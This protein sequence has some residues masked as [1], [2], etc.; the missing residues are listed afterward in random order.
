MLRINR[1][2]DY[3][4]A[5]L[6]LMAEAPN[7]RYSAAWLSAERGLPSPVVSKILKQLVKGGLLVSHRGAK[8]G[9]SL[10]RP[11]EQIS[12]A[13]VITAIEGPIALTDCIEGGGSACQY[14]P[15]CAVSHNW[16]RLNDV[17]YDALKAV[18]L[19]DMSKPLAQEHPVL[20]EVGQ[21]VK[22]A[23]T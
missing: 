11:A 17:F 13:E 9:Y 20:R 4:T 3:A 16:S 12:I 23:V 2:T 22:S 10:V 7:E 14:S 18:S 21:R 6:S 15:L 1:E 5:I 8:G 19:K